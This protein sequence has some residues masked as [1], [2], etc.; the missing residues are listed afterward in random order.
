MATVVKN[1]VAVSIEI[2]GGQSTSPATVRSEVC[3]R[4]FIGPMKRSEVCCRILIGPVK[5][6]YAPPSSLT[7]FSPCSLLP[8]VGLL[9]LRAAPSLGVGCPPTRQCSSAAFTVRRARAAPRSGR[10]AGRAHPGVVLRACGG[11]RRW[12]LLAQVS[13]MGHLGRERRHQHVR[14]LARAS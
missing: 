6:I 14:T 4:I 10:C 7:Y 12:L 11:R 8:G 1:I 5:N 2:N 9:S 3:C 13:P